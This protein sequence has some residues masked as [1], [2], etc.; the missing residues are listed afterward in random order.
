[1]DW[2]L[3]RTRRPYFFLSA[4]IYAAAPLGLSSCHDADEFNKQLAEANRRIEALTKVAESQM[5]AAIEAVPGERW[6]RIVEYTNKDCS[7]ES[8]PAACEKKKA[9]TKAFLQNVGHI[10]GVDTQSQYEASVWVDVENGSGPPPKVDFYQGEYAAAP[11]GGLYLAKNKFNPDWATTG[12]LRRPVTQVEADAIATASLQQAF[13]G[14]IGLPNKDPLSLS[15]PRP[16][17]NFAV[18]SKAAGLL[19]SEQCPTSSLTPNVL[20]E[21]HQC[22]YQ[23]FKAAE[24]NFTS[25]MLS[26]INAPFQSTSESRVVNRAHKVW[27]VL[28][29]RQQL[30]V[31]FEQG[32]WERL[33]KQKVHVIAIIHKTGDPG[34]PYLLSRRYEFTNEYF[35]RNSPVSNQLY[36]TYRWAAHSMLDSFDLD[37]DPAEALKQARQQL[38]ALQK[39]IDAGKNAK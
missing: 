36:G 17:W 11:E 35:D 37:A 7:L 38:D 30:I 24:G 16:E 33:K 31:L 25:H 13:E 28:S 12:E 18:R 14:L 23:L 15:N 6:L 4:L 2:F 8:D 19:L 39:E 29:P 3:G 26:A 1:M 5:N 10:E 32:E 21:I 22:R 27:S 20:F 9:S 34:S